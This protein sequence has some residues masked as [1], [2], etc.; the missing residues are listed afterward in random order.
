M[1]FDLTAAALHANST[2]TSDDFFALFTECTFRDLSL[3]LY[4]TPTG[5]RMIFDRCVFEMA[6]DPRETSEKE[7]VS[8]LSTAASSRAGRL[9]LESP[10]PAHFPPTR[11]LS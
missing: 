8:P 6:E 10:L 7:T 9:E 1:Y 4:R 11:A 2:Q 5:A 3:A